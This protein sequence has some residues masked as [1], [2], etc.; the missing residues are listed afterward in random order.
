M[1]EERRR[2]VRVPV[3]ETVRLTRGNGLSLEARCENLSAGGLGL[4][5]EVR[6]YQGE[7]VRVG[8]DFLAAQTAL[9]PLG[10][11]VSYVIA[12]SY[13]AGLHRI[14]IEFTSLEAPQRQ[15]LEQFI[16]H[17]ARTAAK[18]RPVTVI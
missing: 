5:A 1:R 4:L 2:T 18:P 12:L 9:N 13:P 10:G 14:G 16:V 11:R 6:L 15:A 8:A 3:D 7:A 17:R